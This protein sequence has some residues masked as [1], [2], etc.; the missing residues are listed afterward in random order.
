MG[1]KQGVLSGLYN[2]LYNLKLKLTY[3]QTQDSVL[4]NIHCHDVMFSFAKRCTLYSSIVE[5]TFHFAKFSCKLGQ[6]FLAMINLIRF[7]R[8]VGL[9]TLAMLRKHGTVARHFECHL[10]VYIGISVCIHFKNCKKT[11]KSNT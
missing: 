5:N 10:H 8:Q 3:K 9:S 7:L 6:V 2:E 11:I 1:G 4:Q